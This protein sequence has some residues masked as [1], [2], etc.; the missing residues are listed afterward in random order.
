MNL[1]TRG[2]TGLDSSCNPYAQSNSESTSRRTAGGSSGQRSFTPE[3]VSRTRVTSPMPSSGIYGKLQR[4]SQLGTV[5]K[6]IGY[7]HLGQ[8]AP[9]LIVNRFRNEAEAPATEATKPS[10]LARLHLTLPRRAKLSP[11]AFDGTAPEIESEQEPTSPSL[12][13]VSICGEPRPYSLG[14][15]TNQTVSYHPLTPI[16]SEYEGSADDL[17]RAA[18]QENPQD[19]LEPATSY[20]HRRGSSFPGVLHKKPQDAVAQSEHSGGSSG[21]TGLAS[22]DKSYRMSSAPVSPTS[23]TTDYGLSFI[24]ETTETPKENSEDR[25]RPWVHNSI[26]VH[27]PTR[28]SSIFQGASTSPAILAPYTLCE[29]IIPA[30]DSNVSLPRVPE[31]PMPPS[32]HGAEAHSLVKNEDQRQRTPKTG[33]LSFSGKL[34]K[35]VKFGLSKLVPSRSLQN[36]DSPKSTE[37]QR[38]SIDCGKSKVGSTRPDIVVPERVSSNSKLTGIRNASVPRMDLSANR[39]GTQ[40]D[41][42]KISVSTRMAA[43]LHTNGTSDLELGHVRG[44][45]TTTERFVTPLGSLYTSNNDTS[46]FHSYPQTRSQSHVV[47]CSTDVLTETSTDF[48]SIKSDATWSHRHRLVNA[49]PRGNSSDGGARFNTWGGKSR[50]HPLPTARSMD[51]INL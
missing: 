9:S 8:G 15:G 5:E 46:S 4:D 19:K 35:A 29:N 51:E 16:L 22:T 28:R 10:F 43:L 45:T 20:S 13:Q 36:T 39:Q 27:L 26:Q 25:V 6:S 42:S 41:Q 50:T 33:S 18:L 7:F 24:D 48:D 21:Y 47:L 32:R 17:W 31:F 23:Y 3:T 2:Y 40:R 30:E 37:K 12:S 34:G 49:T 14:S 11:R 38:K 1:L 44:S